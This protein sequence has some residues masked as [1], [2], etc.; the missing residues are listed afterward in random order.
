[1]AH[2]GNKELSFS[3]R[4]SI[5]TLLFKKGDRCDLKNNRP[6]S[7]TNTDYKSIA[8]I[9]ANRL[10][11]VEDRLIGNEQS[12]Y[13]KGRYIG[14][15]A[16]IILDIFDHCT[17]NN[18]K[19]GLLFLDFEKA[20]DS[21]EWNFLFN[22]LQK[23]NFGES[24]ISW[25]KILYNNPIFK[26]KNNGWL[27][28]TCS[29]SRGIRQGCPISAIL[30]IFVAE[31][32]A[33]KLKN[34]AHVKGISIPGMY[35]MKYVQH[36]DDLTLMLNDEMSVEKALQTV[37][38]FCDHA[39]SKVNLHKTECILL[40]NM[41]NRYKDLYGI[42]VTN[43]A[44][45]CLGIYL[46]HNKEQ[47]YIK[48]WVDFEEIQKLFENW[49]RRNLTIFG[50]VCIINSLV[51][52]KFMFVASVLQL[53]GDEFVQ[54]V[55]ISL[56]NFIWNKTDHI[57]RNTIIGKISD[58]GVG[59]VDFELKLR[60]I[61]ASWKN[62][63]T[64]EDIIKMLEFLV[65][66]IFVVFAGKVF[67]QIVGI[68]MGT[69]C[70]PLLADIFLYSYEAEFIQSLLS[71]GKKQLASQFN[72]TYRYIDDVLSINNPD[73]E[74][75][76]GQ[77]YPPEL[78]IKDTTE[79]NTSASYLD[80]LLSIGRDGQLRTSLYDK[81]DDFNFHITNFPFLSSNIPSSPAY[82]V[83][84]SQ[85]IRYARACSS[86]EC[87]ILRA[88]RHSNKLLGQGYVKE[89]LKSSLRKFYGRYGDLTKQ[90]EVSLSRTT[91]LMM[92]IYSDTLH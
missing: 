9:F 71:A 79:S 43:D 45:R 73:F 67:Q 90:Y 17:D 52:S 38:N 49:K 35:E 92:T 74:N 39:G 84:I 66:N 87:F 77:M 26:I 88:M 4:L 28:K 5:I 62:K 46:G 53:P 51:M 23:F 6:L 18:S 37:N 34:N 56:F 15:N 48:N 44:V 54:N 31:I 41:K 32:L 63:Y 40:G 57:K 22:V 91:F 16:R 8:F 78:E 65:D 89:R 10:Q 64:E 55:K 82:G 68:P 42:K 81:R 72:F 86:Y 13:I 29:M 75:Y 27:S 61:K 70:A 36:A 21:V 3:Q 20:F 76:L 83:F 80:L 85:L 7:L 14:E 11:R 33:L 24:F 69:N 2:S 47:C 19:G 50:K 12:A 30:Y 59:I 25:M 60:A 58:G 1:M